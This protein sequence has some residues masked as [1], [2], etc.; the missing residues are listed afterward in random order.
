V[1]GASL[2]RTADQRFVVGRGR[3]LDDLA[4]AGC[5]H[6][7]VI[8]SAHA[9]ARIL[10]VGLD[11]A[12]ALT[13]VAAAWAAKDLPEVPEALPSAY[14]PGKKAWGQSI[15]VH[16]VARYAGEPVAVVVADTPA[17][18]ADALDAATVEYAPLP[19]LAHVDA[20]YRSATKLHEGWA[21]N[22][23]F[24][25]KGSMGDVDSALAGAHVVVRERFRHGRLAAVPI[26]TRGVLAYMEGAT[27]VL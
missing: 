1:I 2:R 22:T 5:L 21:D 10:A 16:D 15:L 4:P 27:L 25:T 3:F 23:A 13:G 8:R 20:A 9:H 17:R 19:T 6:L 11:A 7:G 12:R 14:S 26:E 24:V 18:L